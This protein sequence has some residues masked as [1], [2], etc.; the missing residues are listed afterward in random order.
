[1]NVTDRA[2]SRIA[3]YSLSCCKYIC[4]TMYNRLIVGLKY[5]K[6]L[7]TQIKYAAY[8]SLLR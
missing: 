1:M 8:P 7:S 4:M 5:V 2:V 3:L 6:G